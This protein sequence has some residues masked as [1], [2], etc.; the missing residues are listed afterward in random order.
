M[1][2]EINVRWMDSDKFAAE[3]RNNS[4]VGQMCKELSTRRNQKMVLLREISPTVTGS[5]GI[6]SVLAY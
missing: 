3:R 4:V 2:P 1:L 6:T 5:Q